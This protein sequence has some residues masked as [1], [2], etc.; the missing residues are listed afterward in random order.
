MEIAKAMQKAIAMYMGTSLWVMA[1]AMG[2]T[3]IIHILIH[4]EE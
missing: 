1:M 2:F 4:M 3:V